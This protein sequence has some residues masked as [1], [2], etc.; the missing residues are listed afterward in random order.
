[1]TISVGGREGAYSFVNCTLRRLLFLD[2]R[3][4]YAS[5]GTVALQHGAYGGQRLYLFFDE[6]H[7]AW[8]LNTD[9]AATGSEVLAFSPDGATK[10]DM[11]RKPWYFHADGDRYTLDEAVKLRRG[12]GEGPMSTAARAMAHA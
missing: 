11:L 12:E 8:V 3:P 7:A 6:S 5:K 4:I 1:M 2:G 10:P 9:P